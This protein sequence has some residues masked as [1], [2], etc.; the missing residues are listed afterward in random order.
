MERG[1]LLDLPFKGNRDYVHG[2]DLFDS[3]VARTAPAAAVSLRIHRMMHGL[4]RVDPWEA[5]DEPGAALFFYADES[6]GSRALAMHDSP[7][8]DKARRIPF[9]EA[10]IAARHVLHDQRIEMAH[11]DDAT[12]IERW[13]VLNKLLHQHLFAAGHGRWIFTRIDVSALPATIGRTALVFRSRVGTRLT[14][15]GIEADGRAI[16]DMYFSLVA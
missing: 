4:V 15:V 13:I 2:T 6:G 8:A 9:D 16:G 7:R 14:R 12:F 10:A 1:F 5:G 3:L 11:R